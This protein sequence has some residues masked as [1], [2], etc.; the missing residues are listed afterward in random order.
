VVI[1]AH[2]S[3]DGGLETVVTDSGPGVP[4]DKLDA[5]F[6]PLFTTKPG[7]L[8]MG[9]ALS[10]TIIDAHGGRLWAKNGDAGVGA[11]FCFTLPLA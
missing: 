1:D 6:A 8:G 9:L 4:A 10:R 11:T 5:V 7:G 2:V 3:A